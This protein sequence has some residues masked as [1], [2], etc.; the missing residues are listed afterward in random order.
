M[1]YNVFMVYNL[2]Y[3]KL[4][5]AQ[6]SFYY[7]EGATFEFSTQVFAKFIILNAQLYNFDQ[8]VAIVE[9]KK[10]IQY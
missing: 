7:S 3:E 2:V 8:I 4:S 1:A 5:H 10:Y 9:L 6:Y